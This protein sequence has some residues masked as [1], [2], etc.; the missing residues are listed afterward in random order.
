MLIQTQI[1]KET[2]VY[3]DCEAL[4]SISKDDDESGYRPDEIVENVV[5]LGAA[6]ARKLT[7]AAS[8]GTTARPTPAALSIS[9]AVRVDTNAVV[10]I[11]QTPQKGQFSIK[12]EWR[13]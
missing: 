7:E 8:M 4:Q 1:D 2:M 5:A 13:P 10:A 6:V 11:S 9:F 12:V 3:I